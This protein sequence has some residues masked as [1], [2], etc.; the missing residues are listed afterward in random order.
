[1]NKNSAYFLYRSSVIFNAGFAFVAGLL[2]LLTTA[3][4]HADTAVG[5]VLDLQGSGKIDVNGVSSKLQLLAYLQ[6]R[7]QITVD[8]GARASL[9][10]YATRSV[11]Q[12]T[13]PAVV[14]V[15]KDSVVSLQGQKVVVKAMAEKLVRAAETS[16]VIAGAVRMRQL[17]PRILL[18]TPEANSLLIAKHPAFN[19]IAAEVAEYEVSIYDLEDKLIVTEKV[20]E[21]NWQ[22]PE[23]LVL[24]DGTAYRWQI[25]YVSPKDGKSYTARAE[26]RLASKADAA[27]L[28]D[29]KPE[30]NAALEEWVLYAAM[31]QN[32]RAYAEA[33]AVWQL[34][35]RQ[36]PD[37]LK[38]PETMQ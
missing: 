11:Y 16:N 34:I 19:W 6:P 8:A 4:A 18:V 10:L 28:L 37:L 7:M 5:M 22:L 21:N 31:L 23:K 26:F 2:F 30:E 14:T 36:R 13:G 24:E 15:E 3:M 29:L 12:V 38:L 35:A 1:M 17:P 32:K 20:K 9:S 33:R 27:S 25:S